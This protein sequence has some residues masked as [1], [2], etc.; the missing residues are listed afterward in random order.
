MMKYR[1]NIYLVHILGFLTSLNFASVYFA[2]YILK[3]NEASVLAGNRLFFIFKISKNVL[4]F[5]EIFSHFEHS[6]PLYLSCKCIFCCIR[7]QTQ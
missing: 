3:H 5:Y 6:F 4:R 1:R 2:T 7:T